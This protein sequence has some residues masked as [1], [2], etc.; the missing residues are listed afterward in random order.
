MGDNTVW[1]PL[2]VAVIGGSV[3]CVRWTMR[4]SKAY[5]SQISGLSDTIVIEHLTRQY[6]RATSRTWGALAAWFLLCSGVAF[7]GYASIVE[8]EYSA[9]QVVTVLAIVCLP[10][11]AL[12]LTGVRIALADVPSIYLERAPLFYRLVYSALSRG[13][14]AQ[15]GFGSSSRAVVSPGEYRPIR[16]ILLAT[17]VALPLFSLG[18]SVAGQARMIPAVALGILIAD[19]L[20]YL[21]LANRR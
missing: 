7:I 1:I 15:P 18:V 10:A 19:A 13:I 17:V 5:A 20:A 14:W 4:L 16:I 12:Y 11:A 8:E 3:V 6:L 21:V 2:S 9:L